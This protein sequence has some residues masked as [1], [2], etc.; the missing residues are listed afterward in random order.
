MTA[1]NNPQNLVQAIDSLIDELDRLAVNPQTSSRNFF[2]RLKDTLDAVIQTESSAVFLFG[3]DGTPI[4]GSE[5]GSRHRIED[6][7]PRW[8]VARAELE[9]SEKGFIQQ[10]RANHV[11]LGFSLAHNEALLG[12]LVAS[13]D[14][15][16]CNQATLSLMHALADVTSRF[17]DLQTHRS[18]AGETDFLSQVNEFSLGCLSS[19]DEREIGKI[20]VNDARMLLRCERV[21]YFRVSGNHLKL[22]AVSSVAVFEKRT[23]LLRCASLLA[24]LVCRSNQPLLSSQ[25]SSNKNIQSVADTYREMSGMPFFA[26]FPL[27]AKFR[28]RQPVSVSGVMLIEYAQLPDSFEFVRAAKVVVP[29]AGLAVYNARCVSSIPF[30]KSMMFLSNGLRLGSLVK[31]LLMIGLPLALVLMTFLISTDFKI[32]LGGTLRPATEQLVF[33]PHD[34]FVEKV[35][36]EHG[37]LVSSG[38]LLVHLRSPA[39][40][41]EL[42]ETAKEIVKLSE[43]K[44]AKTIALNQVSNRN[45]DDPSLLAKLASEI[46]DLE[47]QIADLQD[48]QSFVQRRINE[49]SIHAPI[50]GRVVTWNVQKMLTEKPVRW[51]DPLL[52]IADEN[53]QWELQLKAS[54]KKIG[55]VLAAQTGLELPNDVR[56]EYFFQSNPDLKFETTIRETADSTE[57]DP[58]FGPSVVVLCDVDPQQQLKRHGAKVVADVYCGERSIAYVWTYELVDAIRRQFVW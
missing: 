56:V 49:L 30:Y 4:L 40:D 2:S 24:Q 42:E 26:A 35:L 20:V 22:A 12:I 8:S 50:T 19:L 32:R 14:A 38:D 31:G 44:S 57:M 9:S 55:Y 48:K 43:F 17:L 15:A 28:H 34:A 27:Q 46:A 45:A 33:S 21:Q 16:Q 10:T 51:G 29:Q 54:E 53:S 11:A 6:W 13:L 58:E 7:F 23:E 25:P 37:D 47:F 3:P 36:V 5:H 1:S 39:L 18:I 41:L 52:K